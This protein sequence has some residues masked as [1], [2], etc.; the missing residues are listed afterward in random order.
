MMWIE[1]DLGQDS[2]WLIFTSYFVLKMKYQHISMEI[3]QSKKE[4]MV[5]NKK[6]GRNAVNHI[7]SVVSST[8]L[9]LGVIIA[10]SKDV[11]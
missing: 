8:W 5:M 11:D 3:I 1:E 2:P 7:L 9:F 6:D 10:L 4:N